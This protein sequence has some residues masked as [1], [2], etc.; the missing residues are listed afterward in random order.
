MSLAL[1]IFTLFISLL[2]LINRAQF[3]N[4]TPFS[5]EFFFKKM[6]VWFDAFNRNSSIICCLFS[7]YIYIYIYL[8]LGIS[9][10]FLAFFNL[11]L[12]W[13]AILSAFQLPLRSP[14]SYA[15]FLNFSLWSS[16]YRICCRFFSSIKRFLTIIIDHVFSNFS[17]RFTHIF[18]KS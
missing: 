14:F 1:S 4:I 17:C 8:S 6:D 13:L 2:Q 5:I 16:F 9:I 18:S 3:L 10:S 7:G 15:V 11:L 12:E